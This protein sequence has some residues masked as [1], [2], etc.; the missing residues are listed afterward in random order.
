MIG[1]QAWTLPLSGLV[2]VSQSSESPC[3]ACTFPANSGPR[4]T[5][6]SHP[7]QSPI[8]A[9][10]KSATPSSPRAGHA[11]LGLAALPLPR[12]Q[13]EAAAVSTGASL[14]V[15]QAVSPLAPRAG[16]TAVVLNPQDELLPGE[17]EDVD[18]RGGSVVGD[19][20]E[21]FAQRREQVI[22][23]HLIENRVD[24]ALKMNA[25][26]EAERRGHVGDQGEH[27]HP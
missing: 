4:T 25:R 5:Q 24:W 8:G 6:L 19:I 12:H 22:G 10:S 11:P 13:S 1:S 27:L 3:P 17:H 7:T 14:E 16:S 9:S 18:A 20:A 23:E 26:L 21:Q 2:E 15:L